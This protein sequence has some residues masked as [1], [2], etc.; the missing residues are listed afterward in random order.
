MSLDVEAIEL[1]TPEDI[2]N[3][4]RQSI[5]IKKVFK[6]F[7]IVEIQGEYQVTLDSESDFPGIITV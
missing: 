5:L 7:T 2:V 4:I 6:D 1:I 3:E